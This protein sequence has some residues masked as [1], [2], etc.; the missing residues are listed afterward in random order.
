MYTKH[1]ISQLE[2]NKHTIQTKKY[3]FLPPLILM[4]NLNGKQKS[5]LIIINGR[6]YSRKKTNGNVSDIL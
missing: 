4:L 6:L 3:P 2:G 5:L 1:K